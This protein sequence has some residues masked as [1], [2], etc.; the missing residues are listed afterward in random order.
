MGKKLA[1]EPTLHAPVFHDRILPRCFGI[2]VR[3]VGYVLVKAFEGERLLQM[4]RTSKLA[5]GSDGYSKLEKAAGV[6]QRAAENRG[7]RFTELS[8]NQRDWHEAAAYCNWLSEK[9]RIENATPAYPDQPSYPWLAM[10]ITETLSRGYR[11]PAT[12]EWE[13][14]CRRWHNGGLY[15]NPRLINVFEWTIK[16]SSSSWWAAQA[17]S[18]RPVRHA[19]GIASGATMA[20]KS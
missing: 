6:Y 5:A 2:S 18:G 3:E 10:T 4:I 20:L 11:L 13:F 9:T 16:N 7:A 19:G 15:R 8:G 17:Q 12:T 1:T 14:A